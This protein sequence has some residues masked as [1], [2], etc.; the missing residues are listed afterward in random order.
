[1]LLPPVT[2][3]GPITI[4]DPDE[5]QHPL[6]TSA[7]VLA[8]ATGG[9]ITID[10]PPASAMISQTLT[11]KKIDS[12]ANNVT[13]DGDASETIDDSET[14]VLSSQ[15]DSITMLSDGTRWYII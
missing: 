5:V 15:Y 10:L 3:N 13:L 2:G 6:T 1:M 7:I 11:V 12:S 8:D 14:Q 9:A 4:E